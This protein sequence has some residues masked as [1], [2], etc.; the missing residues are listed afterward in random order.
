MPHIKYKTFSLV[1]MACVVFFLM[2]ALYEIN[3]SVL[4][5]FDCAQPDKHKLL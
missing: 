3:R 4:K 1:L 5:G 2:I